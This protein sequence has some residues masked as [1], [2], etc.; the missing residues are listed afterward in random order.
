MKKKILKVLVAISI[1]IIS[2]YCLTGCFGGASSSDIKI[3]SL[4]INSEYN[5]YWEDYNV[6]ITGVAQN[7]S[8][9][10]LSYIIIEF[11]I[12][13][14]HGNIIGSVSDSMNNLGAGESW[15]FRAV[16]IDDPKIEPYSCRVKEITCW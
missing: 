7:T 12:Y 15:S 4:N 2:I 10:D 13:D 1:P 9:Y 5:S 6:V 16:T 8:S 14:K 11:S 3:K